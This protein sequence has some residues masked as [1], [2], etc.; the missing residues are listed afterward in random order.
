MRFRLWQAMQGRMSQSLCLGAWLWLSSAWHLPELKGL[1]YGGLR[2]PTQLSVK[3]LLLG[4]CGTALEPVA[5]VC[6]LR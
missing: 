1:L 2:Q 3:L 5:G 6:M 4:C